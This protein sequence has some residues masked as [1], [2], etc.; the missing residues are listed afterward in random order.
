MLY[1]LATIDDEY[2]RFEDREVTVRCRI[3]G[4]PLPGEDGRKV[5]YEI[6]DPRGNQSL[7]TFLSLWTDEPPHPDIERTEEYVLDALG[8]GRTNAEVLSRGETVLVRGTSRRGTWDDEERLYVNVTSVLIRSPDLQIGKGEMAVNE[9]CPRR[10]YLNYVKKV[11]TSRFPVNGNRFRGNVVHRVAE[12]ALEEHRERFVE[13]SWTDEDV[14]AYVREVLG[15]EF[16]IQMAQLSISGIGL[17]GRDDA[18][19]IATRLFTDK[20]FCERV[21]EAD[22]LSTERSLG[23][24]YGYRGDI[25]LVLDGVPYDFKTSKSANIDRHG[26]QLQLYLFALLLERADIGDD[27]SE[28]LDDVPKGYLVYPNLEGIE[29]IRFAQIV[30]TRD[31]VRDLLELRNDVAA[32]RETFGPPSPY[33]RD[34]EGCRLRGE[35]ELVAPRDQARPKRDPLPSPCKFHCQTERRWPCYETTPDGG[36]VSDC[37]LFDECDERLEYRDPERVD[38]YNR[39]R[40]ALEIEEDRRETASDLLGQLDE[41]VLARSGRLLR[42]LEWSGF[43]IDHATFEPQ[44]DNH[45]VPAFAPGDTVILEPE[46]EGAVGKRVTF[47]GVIDGEYRFQFDVQAN[48]AFLRDDITYRVRKTFEPETVSRKFLSYLDYAQR[49]G[50][51]RRFEHE[52]IHDGETGATTLEDPT[53]VMEYLDNEEVFLDI[54][55]RPDRADVVGSVVESLV[56]SEMKYPLLDSERSVPEEGQRTL[57]LGATPQLVELAERALPDG[58]HYRMDGGGAG[59]RAIRASD[60]YHEIQQRWEESRSLLSSVQYALETEHFHSLVEGAFGNRDHSPRYFDVLVLLGAEQVTEPEYLFLS[61]LADRVVAVGDTRGMGPSMVSTEA[62]ERGL[63]RSYFTWAHGRYASLPVEDAVS[64]RVRGETNEFIQRLYPDD[65][66]TDAE[67]AFSFLDIE[68]DVAIDAGELEIRTAVR[69]RQG[70]PFELV[71]DASDTTA[72]PFEVQSAFESMDYLDAT[73]LREGEVALIDD[74]PMFLE[75]KSQLEA[76][77]ATQH[78]VLIKSAAAQTPEFGRAL[79][80]NRPEARIVAQVADDFEAEMVVSPFETHANELQNWLDEEGVDV[81]VVLP[82]QL[83]R[84]VDKAIVSFGVSSEYGVLRPPLTDPEMLYRLLSCAEE[85]LLVGH[86]ETLRS[87]RDLAWL[88]DEEAAE[89]SKI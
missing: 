67:T 89:H 34:C 37:S 68:G 62:T 36:V 31:D 57:V 10:Y 38:H 58:P 81:P 12:R 76:T 26:K 64:L 88:V 74:F 82:E 27:L 25:D 4:D 5:L 40:K 42:G 44:P 3:R 65:E 14:D 61:D 53:V 60:S 78:R 54:P 86:G 8:T 20:E 33:N 11:Y 85:I 18:I 41:D 19:E 28:R 16:G 79:L 45:R 77:G 83:G 9:Q 6:D 17:W 39:L 46:V 72:S 48:M 75:S 84:T 80:Y 1:D 7:P 24:G 30:L 15:E 22:E 13:D 55:V 66:W 32:S 2:D 23:D 49:R 59:E 50:H 70:G 73:A 21:A 71:F 47:I 29:S 69:S 63:D 51:N 35:E 56:D 43:A 52:Q 87:K